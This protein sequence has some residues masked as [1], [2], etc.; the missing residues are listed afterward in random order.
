[1][2]CLSTGDC[3]SLIRFEGDR[4]PHPPSQMST[5]R[6]NPVVAPCF[7]STSLRDTQ[8]EVRHETRGMPNGAF[9][10]QG[11]GSY[12]RSNSKG[13]WDTSTPRRNM[14]EP[15]D[16]KVK[17]GILPSAIQRTPYISVKRLDI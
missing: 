7:P 12:Q 16:R 11:L 9:D 8:Y 1:M 15:T 5:T 2:D 4:S 13:E 17:C 14:D 6:R 3:A 10:A